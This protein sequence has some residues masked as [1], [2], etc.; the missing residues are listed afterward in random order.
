M[1]NTLRKALWGNWDSST[2]LLWSVGWGQHVEN[3]LWLWELREEDHLLCSKWERRKGYHWSRHWRVWRALWRL[4]WL[5]CPLKGRRR[6]G[7]R[8]LVCKCGS[9]T[10]F[11]IHWTIK[12][13]WWD[14]YYEAIFKQIEIASTS[15]AEH[16][17]GRRSKI[18]KCS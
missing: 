3:I 11:P 7:G 15:A 13:T 2:S 4:V 5:D 6:H 8:A 12:L 17:I 16:F 14:L 9:Q 18:S 1:S 10:L